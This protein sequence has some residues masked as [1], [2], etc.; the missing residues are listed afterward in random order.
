MDVLK[1]V[2]TIVDFASLVDEMGLENVMH[3]LKENYNPLY[4]AMHMHFNEVTKHQKL[5]ALLDKNFGE[6]S[7]Y[8]NPM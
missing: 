2:D 7:G 5:P 8:A 1:E 3:L 6:G 4:I